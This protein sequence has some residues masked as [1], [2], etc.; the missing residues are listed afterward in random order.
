MKNSLFIIGLLIFSPFHSWTQNKIGQPEKTKI[1]IA[2]L[3]DA[4]LSM[5]LYL[6][7]VKLSTYAVINELKSKK[8]NDS[9]FL[10]EFALYEYGNSKVS[11][12]VDFVRQLVSFTNDT[13][14]FN[15]KLFEIIPQG[16][17]EYCASAIENSLNELKWSI[18]TNDIKLIYIYG[19]EAFNQSRNDYKTYCQIASEKGINI[20][21]IFC[22]DSKIG[23]QE[24]W[25]DASKISKGIYYCL[26]QGKIKPSAKT[27]YDDKII[28]Y[29]DSLNKTYFGSKK[30]EI[31]RSSV[32]HVKK[33]SKSSSAKHKSTR[34]EEILNYDIDDLI[35]QDKEGNTISKLD[36]DKLPVEF[37][38]KT[39]QEK[40][41]LIHVKRKQRQLYQ[42]KIYEYEKARQKVVGEGIKI[43]I[44][45]GE[46]DN[47]ASKIISDIFLIQKTKL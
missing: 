17:V 7:Q 26:D 22:G 14:F 38:G 33:A 21:T 9:T 10:L 40:T 25:E 27:S 45:N 30:I 43:R 36:Q 12:E 39:V 11:S 3:I 44:K 31:E 41:T 42:A 2:F 6:D 8:E 15:K 20:N 35:E 24:L 16:G 19:N 5:E 23:I 46:K 18:S 29:T 37:K 28:A 4:S 32:L 1:Q 47:F 13:E 34:P